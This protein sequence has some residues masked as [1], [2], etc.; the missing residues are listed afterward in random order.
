MTKP[1]HSEAAAGHEF[2]CAVCRFVAR[3]SDFT[4]VRNAAGRPELNCSM[5][6]KGKPV[7]DNTLDKFTAAIHRPAG[8]TA[9]EALHV[10]A[11]GADGR[12]RLCGQQLKP[13]SDTQD[14]PPAR[15]WLS[16]DRGQ[17]VPTDWLP[18]AFKDKKYDDDIAYMPVAAH[19]EEVAELRVS[20]AAVTRELD[21][22]INVVG[23]AV[24][25]CAANAT[26]GVERSRKA[27][28]AARTALN[29]AAEEGGDRDG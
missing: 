7:V 13:A 23:R 10:H 5:C 3:R 12:C 2:E 28:A 4:M 17:A 18:F 26:E 6:A 19:D 25:Q 15:I 20:L 1:N 21:E 29:P 11:P 27:I 14:A 8:D 9:A 22:M 24:N 16:K